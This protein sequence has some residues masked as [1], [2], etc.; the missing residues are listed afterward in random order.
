MHYIAAPRGVKA[1]KGGE[2]KILAKERGLIYIETNI[3]WRLT[4]E[5]LAPLGRLD[6]P[7]G[8]DIVHL[9]FPKC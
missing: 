4:V 5:L 7:W 9:L 2:R 8:S 1:T 6:S 3:P